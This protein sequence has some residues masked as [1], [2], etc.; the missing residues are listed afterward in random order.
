MPLISEFRNISIY[1]LYDDHN[2][3]HFHVR[4]AE[5]KASFRIS[6]FEKLAGNLPL[7]SLN[8]IKKWTI[9][10][11]NQLLEVW[12]NA[13]EYKKLPKISPLI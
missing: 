7:N 2:P 4:D 11:E 13:T 6:P 10:N 3:P 12:K 9:V 1:I 5:Y 8:L